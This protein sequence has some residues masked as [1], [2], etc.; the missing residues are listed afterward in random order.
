MFDMLV[1]EI[2]LLHD[3]CRFMLC[4]DFPAQVLSFYK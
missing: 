3:L 2:I 1:Y 4:E